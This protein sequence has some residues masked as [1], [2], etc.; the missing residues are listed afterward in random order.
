MEGGKIKKK[1]QRIFR[2]VESKR[3]IFHGG[4]Q[5][6]MKNGKL[7]LEERITLFH[8]KTIPIRCLS[9]GDLNTKFEDWKL[10]QDWGYISK[11]Y[12]CVW[13][14]RPVLAKLYREIHSA[15]SENDYDRHLVMFCREIAVA[16]QMSIHN[17][18]HKLLACC[19]ETKFPILIYEFVERGNLRDILR[20]SQDQMTPPLG[21]NDRLR[22]AWEISH[23]VAYLH[24]AF[25]RPIIHRDLN[26]LN[27]LLDKDNYAK[28][29]GLHLS[30]CIPKG[31]LHVVG[32]VVGTSGYMDPHYAI[33][34][35]VAENVDVYAFGVLFLELLTGLTPAQFF[36]GMQSVTAAVR[37]DPVIIRDRIIVN[38]DLQQQLQVCIEII[39]KCVA[40][41]KDNR[42]T[43]EEVATE[44]KT[45]ITA[46]EPSLPS[47]STATLS[48]NQSLSHVQFDSNR[49]IFY[50]SH[51]NFIKNERVLL[52]ERVSLF[53]GK[54]SPICR[55]S[56]DDLNNNFKDWILHSRCGA[57]RW[58]QCVWEGR[59]VLAKLFEEHFPE[60]EILV[61]S[62]REIA[63]ATQMSVHKNVH[64]LL[65]CCLE[66]EKPVLI[67]EFVENGCLHDVIFRSQNQVI[68]PLGWEDRLRIAWD[69]SRVVALLHSAFPR[70]IVH[71]D[72]KPMNVYLDQDN[73]AKLANFSTSLS[74]PKG[75]THVEDGVIGTLGYL[76]PLYL[77]TQRVTEGIDVYSFGV[78][79]LV[80]LTGLRATDN[81]F[82]EAINR[83][84]PVHF[85]ESLN[86]AI[87]ENRVLINDDLQQQLQACMGIALNCISNNSRP[88]MEEVSAELQNIITSSEPST[89]ITSTATPQ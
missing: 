34:G 31:E 53:H 40:L 23:A 28:L 76:N 15:D 2:S 50:G 78:F 71:G 35:T 5:N 11:W 39:L 20:R 16:T 19:V 6:F 43:M 1:I 45:I 70:P 21:W 32:E 49:K 63:V 33:T 18:V 64:K 8:G 73:A 61:G 42:P 80:L 10:R 84:T 74:I 17:N 46:S 14:G 38:E 24:S 12:Q 41:E 29:T 22:I 47:P 62:C 58:Y 27:V 3:T 67:Y 68:P 7:L 59:P 26:T 44:L 54:T 48:Q 89:P 69:V 55:L 86:R 4:D 37:L 57:W 51:Q 30:V 87:N 72:L 13:E 82:L 9:I 25:P 52:E 77:E 75:E 79:L 88:T 65:A 83:C 60:N 56:I 66:T 36:Q 85:T 81:E